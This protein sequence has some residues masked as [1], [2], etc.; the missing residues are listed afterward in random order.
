MNPMRVQLV[1]IFVLL[2]SASSP[3]ESDRMYLAHDPSWSGGWL[4]GPADEAPPLEVDFARWLK[5]CPASWGEPMVRRVL[6]NACAAGIR[7]VCLRMQDE[8]GRLLYPSAR[9]EKVL[10]WTN[11][12]VDFG[13]DDLAALAIQVAGRLDMDIKLVADESIG[14][15][16]R[17]RYPKTPVVAP[18]ALPKSALKEVQVHSDAVE[19]LARKH[20]N[21]EP[22]C[23]RKTFEI[24][25]TAKDAKLTITAM[26]TYRA[27]LDGKLIGTD[28]SWQNGE[29]YDLTK[30]LGPGRHV[31]AVAVDAPPHGTWMVGMIANLRWTDASGQQHELVTD[32]TWRRMAHPT[33]EWT[34]VN[35]DDADWQRPVVVGFE[36]TG[37]RFLRLREPWRNPRPLL[38]DE[39]R[40][41]LLIQPKEVTASHEQDKARAAADLAI[42]DSFAPCW[43]SRGLPATLTFTF[44]KEETVAAVRIHSG[45]LAFDAYPSGACE[46]K[47]FKLEARREGQWID[48]T[49][50][51]T[52]ERYQRQFPS[53]SFF[54]EATFDPVSTD[55]I[56]LSIY[57]S[58]DTGLRFTSPSGPA[59][60]LEKRVCKIR[61][62][63]LFRGPPPQR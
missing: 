11:Y 40:D 2:A 52:A 29:T 10:G 39:V 53:S 15:E 22:Q 59:L 19:G 36:G 12:G 24:E 55:A 21:P 13:A 23:F 46:I 57:E 18:E 58:Y 34:A 49:G 5:A 17:R 45:Q 61:E 9:P 42:C 33:G 7:E 26:Q 31:L 25:H 48:L 27:Y 35:Y 3:A 38:S 6:G 20:Q 47:R 54:T 63:E 41:D 44:D 43:A 16:V 51:L 14:P 4:W 50:E 1:L 37:P 28:S 60:P 56:R 8:R 32:T 62:V 30:R